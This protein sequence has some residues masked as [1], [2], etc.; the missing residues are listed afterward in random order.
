LI[1]IPVK[2]GTGE[3]YHIFQEIVI[4]AVNNHFVFWKFTLIMAGLRILILPHEIP[5][6]LHP[7]VQCFF[8][9]RYNP[10]AIVLKEH[11]QLE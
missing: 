4:G 9:G 7:V 3:S 1:F 11:K 2:L 10:M 6:I 8:L 5:L